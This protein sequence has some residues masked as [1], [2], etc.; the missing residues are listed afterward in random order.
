MAK[1]LQTIG[2]FLCFS[3]GVLEFFSAI[4]FYYQGEDIVQNLEKLT[5]ILFG[6]TH[7]GKI[8]FCTY[9]ITLGALR[10]S[11]SL[12]DGGLIAWILLLITH[13]VEWGMWCSFAILPSYRGDST[14]SELVNEVISL[15]SPGGVHALVVLILL[16]VLIFFFLIMGPSAFSNGKSKTK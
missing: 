15:Q 14:L 3:L 5:P 2:R 13:L 7:E 11:W 1:T 16:P 9:L 12:G 4:R 6:T 10:L 8:L